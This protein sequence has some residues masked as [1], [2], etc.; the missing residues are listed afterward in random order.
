MSETKNYSEINKNRELIINEFCEKCKTYLRCPILKT[1]GLGIKPA[2]WIIYSQENKPI[3]IS[4]QKD[5]PAPKTTLKPN[6]H[7]LF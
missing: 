6:E 7:R 1:S 3:C 2:Q 5:R 4:F